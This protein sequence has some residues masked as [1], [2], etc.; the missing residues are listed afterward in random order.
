MQQFE[1]VKR[2]KPGV[3]Y[4]PN[5]DVWYR[6][7]GQSAIK[8]FSGLLRSIAPTEP[9]LLLG[10]LEEGPEEEDKDTKRENAEH[11]ARMLRDLFG[12]SLRNQ[13]KL[14]RP[15]EAARSEYFNAII[16]YLRKSPTE[17]PDQE[18]R[19]R[20]KLPELPEA[21]AD[22]APKGPT[23]ADLKAQKKK[24]RQTLNMLKLHIQSVMDQIKKKYRRFHTP[25]IDDKDIAYLYDEQD[26]QT[27]TTDLN[28][29]QQ[30]QQ[31]LFRPFELDNDEKGVPGLREV[32]SGK[33]YY[34]LEIVTIEKRLSNGY[35]KRPKD[36]LADIKRL[37][38]DAKTSGDQD[39]T[40]KA[41]EMLA[42][43]EVDMTTL[44]QGYPALCAECEAVYE[45]DQE[46]E[47]ER[48]QNMREAE[49]RGEDVP[50]IAPNVPPPQASKTTTESTGP[51]VLGQDIP[52]VRPPLLPI[53]PSRLH[54]MSNP[55]STTNG[56]HQT[57][58]S[59][60]PSRPFED[61][62]MVDSQQDIDQQVQQQHD[63]FSPSQ[64]NTQ[65]QTFTQHSA[66]TRVAPGSQAEQYHNSAST[67]TSGQKTSDKSNRSS[68]APYSINTQMSN[69]V[70]P[71]DHPDFSILPEARGGS[72]LP[73]TQ[74]QQ[75]S[76]QSQP[77]SQPSNNA[78]APPPHRRSSIAAL[79]NNPAGEESGGNDSTSAQPSCDES[80][81][82]RLVVDQTS[83]NKFHEKL[84]K[85]SSGLSVEQLEQVNA[86][87][88]DVIWRERGDWNRL[89][90]LY[91]VQNAF[92]ET[93][94][95]I[96][97]CQAVLGPSQPRG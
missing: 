21:P 38:K 17:F 68:G 16:D 27:L 87:M 47:R 55:W 44:E 22:E 25:V 79:L 50:K 86:S 48:M 41:N 5:V 7:L 3:I 32:A 15:D 29:E 59:T 95:D 89:H 28:Q 61:S 57:N 2:H 37:A 39:R 53:T 83:F 45:R 90:V 92:N 46:R 51:V 36:F 6:T 88:M 74:E 84:V 96:E 30:Q 94:Q 9:I 82:P 12:Y 20:R 62:E 71:G 14:A 1:E 75:Y 33:F 43:V 73:D 42:N 85:N 56:S 70:R 72:Q 97:A 69:G 93:V 81:Q 19:I 64:P 63:P 23:K 34:N 54:P 49:R 10:I 77:A 26:P 76:S 60:V 13:Y 52:G 67:T 40:L 11:E 24:D 91:A 65:G 78:M 4:I 8:T 58:G 35:Y 66:H 18:N 80:K 31:Q